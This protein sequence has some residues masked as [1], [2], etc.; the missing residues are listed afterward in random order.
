MNKGFLRRRA[1]S[2]AALG[3]LAGL[4]AGRLPA[5]LPA[6]DVPATGQA[7]WE[8]RLDVSAEGSYAVRG[9]G[10]P[11]AGQYACRARWEGRLEQDGDDFLLIHLKT[12][13]LEWRLRERSGPPGRETLVEAPAG[14]RPDLRMSYVL[15][16]AREVEFVFE[17]E[18]VSIPLHASPLSVPLE[19][20]R[21]SG[22]AAGQPGLSYGD[23]V[24]RGSCRVVIPE[25][26]LARRSRERRFS[27][28][29]G[30]ERTVVEG[31]RVYVVAQDHTADVVVAVVS[32]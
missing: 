4:A 8:V 5:A 31:G 10:A 28:D 6:R 9:G 14:V 2:L 7:W 20:P 13:I 26:D 27:W 1:V 29:W 24:R 21:T 32:H 11:L 16:D 25:D 30:R 19:L 15:K 3:L 17:L 22:R 12:E 23:L 18:G